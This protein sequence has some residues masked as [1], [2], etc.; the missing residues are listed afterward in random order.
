[1]GLTFL[2]SPVFLDN[3]D[4]G[5]FSRSSAQAYKAHNPAG[6]PVQQLFSPGIPISFVETQ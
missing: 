3:N 5:G 1:M 2:F 4:F 6:F